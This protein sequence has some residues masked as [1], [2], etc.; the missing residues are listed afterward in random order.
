M[1]YFIFSKNAAHMNNMH[2]LRKMFHKTKGVSSEPGI[3]ELD[4]C[5]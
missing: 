5:W 2:S 1:S 3:F 4:K